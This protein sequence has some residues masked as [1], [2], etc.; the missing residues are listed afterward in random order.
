MPS[1]CFD[2]A[3]LPDG[4]AENVRIEIEGGIIVAVETHAMPL[5]SQGGIAL[6]GLASLHSHTFQRGMA[7]LGETRGPGAD[8]FWSWR[9]VMYR[10]LGALTPED[11]EAIAAYAFMEMLE[12]GFTAVGEFHYLHHGIGGVAYANLAEH[13]ERI[14]AAAAETGI[15]LTLLPVFY[16]QGGFGAAPPTEGQARFVT[17][18]EAYARLFDA[19]KRAI[20][21]L[22][23]ANIGIAPHSLRAVTPESLAALLKVHPAGPI[24]IHIAEQRREVEECLAW[25]DRR[26]VEWL[27]DHVE[28]DQ[29]WCL[30]HATHMSEAE[31]RMVARSGA[32]AGLCPITEANLGDG[33]FD[34]PT[35]L[36]NSGRFGVGTDSNVEITAPGELKMLEYSQRLALRARNIFPQREGQSTGLALYQGALAGGAQALGRE[37]GRIEKGFRADIVVLDGQHPDLAAVTGDRWLDSYLFVAGAPT[38]ER[39]YVGGVACVGAGRHLAREAITRRYTKALARLAAL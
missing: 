5:P 2:A 27:Y 36:A 15:G 10:F 21:P 32:V 23:D 18:P 37:I 12:T 22:P 25:S 26:P 14:A 33:I 39:V 29:R 3:L 7:G 13:A 17:S 8:S 16:A 11:I 20:A 28:V 31:G 6:P 1:L 38:I 30:I 19:S 24:H 34:A 35:L 9:Q 4:W